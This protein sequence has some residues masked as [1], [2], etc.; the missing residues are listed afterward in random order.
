MK[1]LF[2]LI[3]IAFVATPAQM[4]PA[5]PSDARPFQIS[6]IGTAFGVQAQVD[7]EY[8]IEADRIRLR[9]TKAEILVSE[10]C[11]Y[12]GRRQLSKL[13]IDL[14]T[15]LEG[16]SWT[17]SH[18]GQSLLLNNVMGP[19][20]KFEFNEVSL[21]IPLEP[22]TNLSKHWLVL[23]IEEVSLDLPDLQDRKGYSFAHSDCDVFNQAA[24]E[25][26]VR[27]KEAATRKCV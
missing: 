10:H 18:K 13:R 25:A 20:E 22:T 4:A 16:R 9:I 3:A 2:T 11:P 12:K 1:F 8:E 7:G 6:S 14:A 19:G 27:D 21:D 5:H 15:R 26:K 24:Y 17:S 23:M